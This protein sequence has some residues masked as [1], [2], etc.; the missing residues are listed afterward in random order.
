MEAIHD[1][2]PVILDETA[3]KEWAAPGPM[4]TNRMAAL[5]VSYPAGEMIAYQVSAI[6]NNARNDVPECV[7][8]INTK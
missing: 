5:C 6:V 3:A 8:P 1:R 7:A 2:M 4:P